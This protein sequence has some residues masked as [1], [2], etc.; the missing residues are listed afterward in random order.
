MA[1]AT[2]ATA[3]DD[4]VDAVG[5]S[6]S[7]PPASLDGISSFLSVMTSSGSDPPLRCDGPPSAT[8]KRPAALQGCQRFLRLTAAALEDAAGDGRRYNMS[9]C[10]CVDRQTESSEAVSDGP[11]CHTQ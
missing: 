1:S 4:S 9:Q 2:I 5:A 10:T 6:A 8:I 3:S 7:A 11:T